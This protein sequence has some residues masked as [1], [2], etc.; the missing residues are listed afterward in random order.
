M[1]S[2]KVRKGWFYANPYFDLY[3]TKEIIEQQK[4]VKVKK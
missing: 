2:E 3:D 1:A 4:M